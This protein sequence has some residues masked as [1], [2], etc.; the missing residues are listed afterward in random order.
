M[1]LLS[2]VS[3]KNLE[4]SLLIVFFTYPTDQNVPQVTQI[5]IISK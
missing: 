2:L 3:I 1:S 4:F 5:P